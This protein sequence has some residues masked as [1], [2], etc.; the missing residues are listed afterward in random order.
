[1]NAAPLLERGQQGGDC[2]FVLGVMRIF[3]TGII[4]QC[5]KA[6]HEFKDAGRRQIS[7]T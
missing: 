4:L 7:E 1:M 2:S 5:R 3:V 6:K